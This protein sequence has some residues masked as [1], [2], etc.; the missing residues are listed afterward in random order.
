MLLQIGPPHVAEACAV[1]PASA[2]N[3]PDASSH[4]SAR[5][6]LHAQ[7]PIHASFQLDVAVNVS[8]ST[9]SVR[10]RFR[11][12]TAARG[13]AS[14]RARRGGQRGREAEI[15]A[16]G[17]ARKGG[18]G[19]R[20]AAAGGQ[21]AREAERQSLP[22]RLSQAEM[23][24]RVN[25]QYDKWHVR[26]RHPLLAPPVCACVLRCLSARW[27]ALTLAYV[28]AQDPHNNGT[29]RVLTSDPPASIT[30][31]RL[32]GNGKYTDHVRRSVPPPYAPAT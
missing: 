2:D 23:L 26:G 24:A 8:C 30:L 12:S 27:I 4:L 17:R 11:G 19:Q 18:G 3:K 29:Y 28:C 1:L 22:S 10:S 13:R 32:T 5:M 25:G 31:A 6:V 21:R 14:A 7:A 16:E 20:G 15:R 9:M